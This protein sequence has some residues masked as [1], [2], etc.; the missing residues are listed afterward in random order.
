MRLNKSLSSVTGKADM[1]KAIIT[2][3][4]LFMTLL[5]RISQAPSSLNLEIIT[6]ENADQLQ[7]IARWESATTGWPLADFSPDGTTLALVLNDGSLQ[8][9]STETLETVRSLDDVN[10]TGDELSFSD[11][12]SRL[13][14]SSQFGPFILWDSQTGE[15]LASLN[16]GEDGAI[17]KPSYDL[18]KVYLYH[19]NGDSSI[20]DIVT[21]EEEFRVSSPQFFVPN[22]DSSKVLTDDPDANVLVWDVQSGEVIQRFEPFSD[23]IPGDRGFLNGMGFTPDGDIWVNWV[24]F[25]DNEGT[26]TSY[27]P[28]Q[29]WD[30]ESGQLMSALEGQ[31]A[32]YRLVF[33]PTG[34]YV[35][36][37]GQDV[38]T[39]NGEIIVWE[40]ETGQPIGHPQGDAVGR[41]L[42]FDPTGYL[43]TFPAGSAQIRVHEVGNDHPLAVLP[44]DESYSVL[45]FSADGR[46]LLN[47]GNDI[48]LWGVPATE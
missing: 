45:E 28:I 39:I 11:N 14:L 2:I 26:P 47:V 17:Y 38:F 33:D 24:L 9:L 20:H 6:P 15:V 25:S 10:V 4:P 21:L 43:Y 35:V 40:L 31:N 34:T 23:Q 5:A 29:F 42:S 36:S 12:G 16:D 8:F 22:R 13:I 30:L 48:R 27:S 1:L 19:E 7:E 37:V 18:Q 44:A 3:I 32:Y 46:L 41:L